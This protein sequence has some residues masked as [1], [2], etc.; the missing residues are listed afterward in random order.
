MNRIKG[1]VAVF[2]IGAALAGGVSAQSQDPDF[3]QGLIG[4][5]PYADFGVQTGVWGAVTTA[6]S[7]KGNFNENKTV[8]SCDVPRNKRTMV[9]LGA[10]SAAQCSMYASLGSAATKVTGGKISEAYSALGTMDSKLDTL[11]SQQKLSDSA[12]A[13]IR[14]A[15]IDA[16]GCVAQLP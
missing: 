9:S 11:V 3:C 16:K 4:F 14:A 12:R 13:S 7:V 6:A 5:Y 2:T 10:M 1:S 15:L 8:T